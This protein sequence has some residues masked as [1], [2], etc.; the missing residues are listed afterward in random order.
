MVPGRQA[1]TRK[2]CAIIP[3]VKNPIDNSFPPQQRLLGSVLL[4]R[5]ILGLLLVGLSIIGSLAIAAHRPCALPLVRLPPITPR[6]SY[7]S[8]RVPPFP[9]RIRRAPFIQ[10]LM[11][12]VRMAHDVP[13]TL[14]RLGLKVHS[15]YINS[16]R[17]RIP[18]IA[19]FIPSCAASLSCKNLIARMKP[20]DFSA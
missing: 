20:K 6:H 1:E 3:K 9:G 12:N 8:I 11:M 16:H 2:D 15:P 19:H 13:S 18:T 17:A 7:T 10:S 5:G 4:K 14:V